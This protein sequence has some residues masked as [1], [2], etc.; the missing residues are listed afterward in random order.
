MLPLILAA[1]EQQ[2][3]VVKEAMSVG[4]QLGDPDS[5]SAESRAQRRTERAGLTNQEDG[6]LLGIRILTKQKTEAFVNDSVGNEQAAKDRALDE[7]EARPSRHVAGARDEAASLKA[8]LSDALRDTA[9]DQRR[10]NMLGR[11][12]QGSLAP[13]GLALDDVLYETKSSPSKA[14]Q[15]ALRS[16][17]K[18]VVDRQALKESASGLVARKR[19][20]ER[21]LV[22][23]KEA[24]ERRLIELANAS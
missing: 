13:K 15:R 11:R 16:S 6:E 22:K 7:A 21:R 14:S 2:L 12:K 20:D 8:F 24:E 23:L 18:G 1:C 3:V 17:Q 10:A 19:A 5:P 4:K 9:D